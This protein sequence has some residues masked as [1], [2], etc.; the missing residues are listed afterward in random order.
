[1]P[2]QIKDE[3]IR[4]LESNICGSL[5]T[6]DNN[7]RVYCNTVYYCFDN[8]LNLYFAS[9]YTTNHAE[10]LKNNPSVALCV[11]TQPPSYGLEHIG[12][13]IMGECH[14]ISG[15]ELLRAWALYIKRFNVFQQKIGSF[16]NLRDKLV[17][18]RLY[19][20]IPE[21]IKVTNSVV[22]G[23]KAIDYKMYGLH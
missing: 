17:S 16:E 2:N 7:N 11:W 14:L 23:N 9:D 6:I 12:L 10:Y 21:T 8:E 5:S 19:K 15:T 20:V 18:I 13:Q 4:I 1:M 3:I 22:L